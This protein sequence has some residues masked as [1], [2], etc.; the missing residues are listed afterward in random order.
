MPD[1]KPIKA[2]NQAVADC[3]QIVNKLL[4]GPQH[5]HQLL[6]INQFFDRIK[7]RL[8]FM[9]G[10]LEAEKPTP[11]SPVEEKH[12]PIKSFM[13]RKIQRKEGSPSAELDP[14]AAQKKAF[15][16]KVEKLF[17]TI[18]KIPTNTLLNSYSR[19]DD[20][21]VLRGVAKRAGLQGF[22][23]RPIDVKFIDDVREAVIKK[24][25]QTQAHNTAASA[26]DDRVIILTQDEI[27]INE[28]LQRWGAKPGDKLVIK[29]GGEKVLNPKE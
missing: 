13:G 27:E 6:T 22:D 8:N 12:P 10:M 7:T 11:G 25:Q 24:K 17:D 23:K 2:A 3:K 28:E 20:V 14:N 18:E 15:L 26:A 4:S 5:V 19:P 29:P 21:I 16:D 1:V 9:G